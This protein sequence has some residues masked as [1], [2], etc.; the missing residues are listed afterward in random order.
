MRLAPTRRSDPRSRRGAALP[1]ALIGLVAVSL[2]VTTVLLTGSTEFAISAAHRNASESLFGSDAALERFVSDRAAEQA[3]SGAQ[4]LFAATTAEN[5]ATVT[6]PDGVRYSIHVARLSWS[7]NVGDLTAVQLLANEVYSLIAAPAGGRG[8]QVG[9][10]VRARRVFDP[11][12]LRISAGLT[13]GGDLRV[14]GNAVIADGGGA[15]YCEAEENRSEFAI[16]VS[17]GSTVD[18]GQQ[19]DR[20][21][22]GEINVAEWTKQEMARHILNGMTIDDFAENSDIK[23]GRRWDRPEWGAENRRRADAE[24]GTPLDYNWGC[25]QEILER[26]TCPTEASRTR[27]VSV[28][29]DANGGEVILNGDY[30]QGIL[31]V[32]NGSLRIQGNFVFKGIVLVEQDIH[33]YGG[34]GGEES[35]IQGA[36]LAFGEQ[37][38]VE[39]NV[40]GTATIR[41]NL[42]AVRDA[43][44]ALNRAGL[45]NAPQTRGGGTFAW[46]ELI[47]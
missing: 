39:D 14:S 32:V 36:V 45:Q 31:I 24:S 19:G 35:K 44:G 29:I 37:T 43:E 10:F 25:P 1:V 46:Y 15:N 18:A 26:T 40:S 16:Q 22:E 5:P 28:A 9:A 12:S 6:G 2:L 23:F 33:I 17:S 47:R 4:L 34:G 8:R 13:S 42:C 21:V 30:G 20:R 7:D 27:L 38:E 11:V 3:A 41:Y